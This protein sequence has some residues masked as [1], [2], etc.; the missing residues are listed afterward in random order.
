MLPVRLLVGVAEVGAEDLAAAALAPPEL[1][2]EAAL[3]PV[4]LLAG[5]ALAGA[6]G[7]GIRF[8]KSFIK[9]L[10][11]ALVPLVESLFA[12]ALASAG[13]AFAQALIRSAFEA[14]AIRSLAGGAACC[15]VFCVVFCTGVFSTGFFSSGVFSSGF[16]S[17]GL[18]PLSKP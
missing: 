8:F 17:T 3:L 13:F 10:V 12:L 1:I 14:F 11:V 2:E 5:V 6:A 15:V 4:R 16:F 18:A 9:G 7:L